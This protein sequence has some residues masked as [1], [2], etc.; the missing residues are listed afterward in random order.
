VLDTGWSGQ[1]H[2]AFVITDGMVTVTV[3]SCAGTAPSCGVCNY[4]GPVETAA[5][6]LHVRRCQ[7][8][9]S[10]PSTT[11][12]GC[13]ANAPCKFFFGTYLPLA[14]GGVST[15]V[16]NTFAAGISGTANV[17]TGTS[18]GAA[19]VT[20]RVF[21]GL[22]IS[23]PCP[24]CLG[25]A[26]INDGTQGGTCSGGPRNG[27]ACDASGSSPNAS[28]GTTSL[29]CPPTAGALIATLPIDLSNT[30]GT[31]T[32]TLSAANPNCRS[33]GFTT[34]KCQCDTCNNA[35]ATPC[36]SN[37][38][39]VAVGATICGGRRCT[40]GTNNGAPC[41]LNS[42][43]PGTGAACSVP[44]AA[45][46]FN[47]CDMASGDC[48]PGDNTN[49]D[50]T[51]PNEHVCSS[52]PFAQFCAPVETFRGCTSNADCNVQC[53]SGGACGDT[54]SLGRFRECFDNGNIGD[55]VIATGNADPPS[56]HQSDPTLAALFCIGPT[57]SGAV[58][59]A[60]G[61]PGLGRLQLT[62]HSVDNGTP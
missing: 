44:G 17:N 15:C 54:C 20:S 33:A 40:G 41:A 61:L 27:M 31:K 52:G 49:D 10:I 5:G 22:S 59:A 13:G 30:T 16:Q 14:A 32:R 55:T 26:V 8:D 42:E 35:A 19:S 11:D 25:D 60:A 37:A 56:G 57:T 45:T 58:N 46:L 3:T 6:N 50:F 24:R 29:D 36:S 9:S 2:D 34:F 7:G 39:C 18:A 43:C 23:N 21:N 47:Q 28:F 62:G 1:A 48:V 51:G 53:G 4:T 38:D 12:A